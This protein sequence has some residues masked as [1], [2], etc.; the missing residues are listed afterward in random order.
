V[1][2]KLENEPYSGLEPMPSVRLSWKVTD[3]TLL[4][5]AVSRAVRAPTPVDEDIRELLGPIDFLS[6]SSSFVPEVLTA[7][8]LGT[9]V[10]ASPRLSFSVSTFYNVY[11]H[12]RSIEPTPNTVLPLV[13]SNMMRGLIYGA[14]LWGSYRVTD[15]WRLTAGFNIQHEHLRFEPGS[16]GFGGLPF[17]ADDPSHQASLRSSINI[18]EDVTWDADLRYVGKLPNPGVPDYAELGTRVGWKIS[19]ALEVSISGF[20]LLHARHEEFLEPGQSFEIPRSFFV[21]TR[22][23]F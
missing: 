3:T 22:W 2:L 11:D 10:Q 23:R 17:A 6:G 14:E 4:W 5:G 19:P 13:F 9:R 21:E 16:S 1:G 18:G 20:N 8:E 7:Y 12:L 15:W